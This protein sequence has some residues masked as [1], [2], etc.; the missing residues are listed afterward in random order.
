MDS[1][2]WQEELLARADNLKIS[3]T[4]KDEFDAVFGKQIAE[5]MDSYKLM[6]NELFNVKRGLIRAMRV[7]WA[8]SVA[9]MVSIGLISVLAY[10][11]KQ[12]AEHNERSLE[13]I[14]REV[15][16]FNNGNP[17]YITQHRRTQRLICG[18]RPTLPE[19]ADVA[20]N[21]PSSP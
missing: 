13:D 21:K 20:A 11:A 19:C 18:L 16:R 3:I 8:L 10:D 9:L 14:R 17:V 12:A 4:D 5:T 1:E 2:K 6:L 15:D 7:F